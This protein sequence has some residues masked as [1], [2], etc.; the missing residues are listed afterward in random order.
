[1]TVET[2]TKRAI[3]VNGEPVTTRAATLDD[4]VVELG[5]KGARVATARNGDFVPAAV[6]SSTR[7]SDGDTIEVVSPRHG[8]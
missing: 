7:L 4:L 2:Q 8:G 1:M 3:V 6:R 5:L